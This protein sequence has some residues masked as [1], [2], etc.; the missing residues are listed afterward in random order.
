MPNEPLA[1]LDILSGLPD[2]ADYETVYAAVM[3][4]ERGRRFLTEY[5]NRNRQADTQMLVGAIARVEAA[6][7]G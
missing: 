3:A 4:S 6:I 7:R 1:L 5:A 2:E